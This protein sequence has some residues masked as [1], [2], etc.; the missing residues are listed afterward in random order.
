L[1]SDRV[2]FGPVGYVNSSGE[3]VS[4]GGRVVPCIEMPIQFP[5]QPTS[6]HPG[7][8]GPPRHVPSLGRD[9]PKSMQKKHQTCDGVPGF[10]AFQSAAASAIA[11]N[12]MNGYT[13]AWLRGIFIHMDFTRNI[14]NFPLF[15]TTS[16]VNVSYRDGVVA[17]WLDLGSVRPDAVS[18][19]INRPNFVVEL[20]T[21][22][23]RLEEPQL[24]NYLNNL[25]PKTP[26]CEI[27]EQGL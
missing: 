23:A 14:Q 1:C 11:K 22:N 12:P 18:G 4:P 6:P 13:P 25:P 9:L 3:I 17:G 8:V 2:E 7:A 16:H 5:A 26:I 21:G 20:K 19:Y 27:F 15:G 24:S 10:A